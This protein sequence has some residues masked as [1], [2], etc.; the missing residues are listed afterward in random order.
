MLFWSG[1]SVSEVGTQISQLALPTLA[2][3]LFHAGYFQIGLLQTLEFLPFLILGLVAGVV[4][5][6]IRRRPLMIACDLLRA[7]SLASIPVAY[8]LGHLTLAQVLLVALAVGVGNVFFAIGYQSHLPTLV[9]RADLIE[10]NS[11]L[12]TTDSVAQVAGP[13]IA[14]F[15]I[16]LLNATRAILLD[17]LSYIVSAA[18]LGLIRRAE[19]QPEPGTEAGRRGFFVEMGEGIGVVFSNPTIRLI[20]ACTAT[21]NLGSPMGNAVYLVFAYRV[22]GLSPGTVGLIF[23]LF[24]VSAVVGAL[25]ASTWSRLFGLGPTLVYGILLGGVASALLPL[26][27]VFPRAG[28]P[29]LVA[30]ALLGGAGG[31]IYNINQVSLRQAIVPDRVQGRMNATVRTIVWGT[32]P[33]ASLAGGYLGSTVGPFLTFLI[34][35][36]LGTVSVVW[37]LLGPVRLRAIPQPAT[38]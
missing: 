35:G 24:G 27:A 10:G 21:C 25:T 6:R 17:A 7:L 9:D 3:F 23:G 29:L 33:I 32:I 18:T 28:V 8:Y 34:S 22:L 19:P 26:A 13:A 20:T 2:V 15:V 36:S 31:P 4:A 11:K 16:Q 14:G 5:D 30:N 12:Q 37:L 1:Q 38:A